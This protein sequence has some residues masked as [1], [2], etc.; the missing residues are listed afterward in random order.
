MLKDYN[1]QKDE[2]FP[3]IGKGKFH[4]PRSFYRSNYG[5]N[6]DFTLTRRMRTA[7]ATLRGDLQERFRRY[8]PNMQFPQVIIADP[9]STG[10]SF[11]E[12]LTP[13]NAI[14]IRDR[15]KPHGKLD[16]SWLA[17]VVKVA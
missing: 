2:I 4:A 7:I 15:E 16:I 5:L 13:F 6:P 10:D 3:E 8:C 11:G 12:A 1:T 17:A 9:S 14:L